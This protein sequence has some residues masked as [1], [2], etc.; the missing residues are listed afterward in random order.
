MKTKVLK[1]MV[2]SYPQPVSTGDFLVRYLYSFRNRLSEIR[3]HQGIN[4]NKALAKKMQYVFSSRE[5]W[6]KAQKLLETLTNN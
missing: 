2:Q 4:Y 3:R 1:L 6:E 5:D